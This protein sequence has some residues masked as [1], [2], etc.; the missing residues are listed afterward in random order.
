MN[1]TLKRQILK[2]LDQHHTMR[3][4]TLRPDTGAAYF[5][6]VAQEP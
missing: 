4:A 2:L 5:D 3:I 1:E 6:V